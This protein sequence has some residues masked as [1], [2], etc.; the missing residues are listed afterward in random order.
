[1]TAEITPTSGSHSAIMS[2]GVYRPER[3]VTNE[4]VCETIDSTDEWIRTR[5]GIRSRRFAAIDETSVTMGIEAGRKAIEASGLA[6]EQVDC[7][8]MATSSHYSQTPQAATLVADALGLTSPGS[9]DLSAGC[10]GFCHGLAVASDLIRAG[11]STHVLV[12]G[13]DHMSPS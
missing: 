8:I 12:I 7:I 9:F 5:S 3:V 11:S 1:M 2:L 6:P 4:E 10:A 13:V